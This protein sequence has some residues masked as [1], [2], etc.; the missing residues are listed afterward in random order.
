MDLRP[1]AVATQPILKPSNSAIASRLPA[2]TAS[3]A[4]GTPLI[5]TTATFLRPAALS[6]SMAPS[7]EASAAAIKPSMGRRDRR[8]PPS[9]LHGYAGEKSRG[10][11]CAHDVGCPGTGKETSFSE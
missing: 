4:C 3:T 1:T 7:A 6:A 11:I 2:F 10:P 8:Q 5:D 9:A